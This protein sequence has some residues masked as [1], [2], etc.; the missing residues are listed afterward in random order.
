MR[1]FNLFSWI[2]YFFYSLPHQILL[3]SIF[4]QIHRCENTL[5]L[6][7]LFWVNSTSNLFG[8][9]FTV[10]A[11]LVMWDF[12]RQFV[13]RDINHL[14]TFF[15]WHQNEEE[16]FK[17]ILEFL[18]GK[19]SGLAILQEVWCLTLLLSQLCTYGTFKIWI[20]A[21]YFWSFHIKS[22]HLT[23]LKVPIQLEAN[24]FSLRRCSFFKFCMSIILCLHSLSSS[25]TF[26]FLFL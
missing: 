9:F 14:P 17:E 26:S 1:W 15:F 22:A 20:S 7:G 21:C 5:G 2:Y 18:G 4:S 8:A 10:W 3:R 23:L 6:S 19:T 25:F 11:H 24:V 13:G 12:P 16:A